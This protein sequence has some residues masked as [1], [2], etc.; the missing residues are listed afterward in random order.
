[1]CHDFEAFAKQA[2]DALQYMRDVVEEMGDEIKGFSSVRFRAFAI[3]VQETWLS[4]KRFILL[5]PDAKPGL[6]PRVD[7]ASVDDR[8]ITRREWYSQC[9]PRAAAAYLLGE[10]DWERYLTEPD[11]RG[12]EGSRR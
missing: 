10:T 7:L 4:K 9:P 12:R 5:T 3:D 6:K 2:T 1:M 11:T 8:G